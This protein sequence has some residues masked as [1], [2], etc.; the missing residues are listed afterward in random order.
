MSKLSFKLFFIFIILIVL[1]LSV[2]GFFINFSVGE[3]FNDFVNMQREDS[4]IELAEI[5]KDYLSRDNIN[6]SELNK[7]INNF[8]R[9]NRIPIWLRLAKQ[10]NGEYIYRPGTEGH[11]NN[12][13]RRMG[14]MMGASHMPIH[15]QISPDDFPGKTRINEI[16][17]NDSTKAYIYWK[18][19]AVNAESEAGIYQYFKKS[20]F[21][22]IFISGIF[23]ATAAGLMAFFLS[24]YITRPLLKLN[25]SALNVA[26][27][28][29]KQKVNI[30]GNDELAQLG[31]S[32]NIMTDKLEKLE[33]IRKDSTSDLAHELR[34]PVTTI[35]G[36]LEAVEDGLME[37]DNQTIKELQE[38]SERLIRLINQLQEYSEA[39]N[40]IIN[41]NKERLDLSSILSEI[42]N[43][44]QFNIK[45]KD[46]SVN[47][48]LAQNTSITADRDS[49]IQILSN[50]IENAVKY[51]RVGGKINVESKN[52]NDHIAVKIINTG[53][54]IDQKDLPFIFERFYRADQSRSKDTGGTGIGLAVTK[55]LVEAHGG[56]ISVKSK[57]EET[58]FTIIL[59]L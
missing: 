54:E 32:F 25:R 27:G 13:M 55:E 10:K 50:L 5:L 42:L 17:I 18:E 40:K 41:L 49:M 16:K 21:N 4:I 48:D 36:Y 28:N 59:P 8:T 26:D 38:E 56:T 45:D 35:K 43:K 34:T 15:S 46:I 58:I 37:M 3:H 12:M 22:A 6:T 23:V 57:K 30:K 47:L 53:P 19:I 44:Y 52:L 9:A 1:S 31:E 14:P 29:Y 7:I 11:M 20:V 51:N 24:K 39:Q 33:K 2:A